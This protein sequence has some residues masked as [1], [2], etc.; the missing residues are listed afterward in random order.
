MSDYPNTTQK[1]RIL[2]VR[3]ELANDI[4]THKTFP[5]GTPPQFGYNRDEAASY[6]LGC[7]WNSMATWEK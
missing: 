6:F 7:G 3:S 5:G 4:I 1:N 2:S